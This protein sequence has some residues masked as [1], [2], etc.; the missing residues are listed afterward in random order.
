MAT[1]NLPHVPTM[2]NHLL[3][4]PYDDSSPPPAPVCQQTTSHFTRTTTDDLLCCPYNDGPLPR[5]PYDNG[6]A[7]PWQKQQ[8]LGSTTTSTMM[9]GFLHSQTTM[10]MGWD[11][12]A[13]NKDWPALQQP[14]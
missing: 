2:T 9:D 10:T 14:I 11:P 13:Q 7:L 8:W 12:Y 5:T 3:R 4:H 6:L 1:G